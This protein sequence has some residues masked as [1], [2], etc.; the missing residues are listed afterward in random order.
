MTPAAIL[1]KAVRSKTSAD[2][3][4][5][6]QVAEIDREDK[7]VR[8]YTINRRT[9]KLVWLSQVERIRL[10]GTSVNGRRRLRVASQ[11]DKE[12]HRAKI[13]RQPEASF[14]IRDAEAVRNVKQDAA[15]T[16]VQDSWIA[17]VWRAKRV[18]EVHLKSELRRWF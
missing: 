13:G 9:E 6:D 7:F 2:L 16:M 1:G 4:G 3:K 15:A 5:G 10:D 11:A 12:M 8:M 14:R 18:V 17:G